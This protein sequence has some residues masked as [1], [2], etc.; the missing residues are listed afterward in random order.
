MKVVISWLVLL[1]LSVR[2]AEQALA[3][4]AVN[5]NEVQPAEGDRVNRIA[6]APRAQ[7]KTVTVTETVTNTQIDVQTI[8]AIETQTSTVHNTITQTEV[9]T[10]TETR[11]VTAGIPEIVPAGTKT[12]TVDRPTTIIQV[13]TNAAATETQTVTSTVTEPVVVKR[14]ITSVVDRIIGPSVTTSTVTS[15]LAA[16]NTVTTTVQL[17]NSEAAIFTIAS[18]PTGLTG[19]DM[20]T[21]LYQAEYNRAFKREQKKIKGQLAKKE[22]PTKESQKSAKEPVMDALK[23][24]S[25]SSR[26]Y[27]NQSPC[28]RKQIR[29]PESSSSSSDE[30]YSSSSSRRARNKTRLR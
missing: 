23:R 9:Q 1:V 28:P 13:V 21:M 10:I 14:A 17:P 11:T 5:T 19:A 27:P 8:T 2:A 20:L 24:S 16:V 25:S 6:A 4:L 18:L 29:I 3:A 22:R 7:D 15:T 30:S 26:P 12:V